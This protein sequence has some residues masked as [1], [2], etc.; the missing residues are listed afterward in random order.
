[1]RSLSVLQVLADY[2]LLIGDVTEQLYR[3]N[4]GA[5]SLNRSTIP[6]IAYGAGYS[7]N[8]ATWLRLRYP[9]VV[10]G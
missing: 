4:P 2:T 10:T 3:I 6:V 8:L 1:M 5:S 7:G 9:N